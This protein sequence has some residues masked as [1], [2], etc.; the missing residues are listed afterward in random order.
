MHTLPAPLS[1][2]RTDLR[3]A[4]DFY[5]QNGY[6]IAR[7]VVDPT[8]LARLQTDFDRTVGQLQQSGEDINARWDL[9]TTTALDAD[10]STVVIHTHQIQKYSAAW[11]QFCFHPG[12]LDLCEAFVGPDIILHHTKLFLKPAGRGAAFPPHQDQSYFPTALDTMFAAVLYL[13]PSN[14]DNG[15]V[16]V[17]PGSHHLGPLPDSA[18]G[19]K[20]M[21]ERFPISES[22]PA[23]ANPGDLVFFHA[24]TVH[25]SLANRGNQARKSVLFQFHS[26]HD[27][28]QTGGH[29]DSNLVVRGWNHRMTRERANAS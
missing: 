10:R 20:A 12:F 24:C 18:G 2:Q 7:N 19:A 5:H 26:G 13:S 15:C 14:E 25:A 16:R 22:I 6:Y 23:I 9:D 27:Q 28:M 21:S 17:W 4:A 11:A 29:P 1:S 3:E 8:T